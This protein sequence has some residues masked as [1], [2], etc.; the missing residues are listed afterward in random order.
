M[1]KST[2][3]FTGSM[4]AL[5][6]V[7]GIIAP[8][9]TV[10]AAGT[11]AVEVAKDAVA[12]AEKT[13]NFFDWNLA[14]GKVVALGDK[15]PQY[16]ELLARLSKIEETVKT[17]DVKA[18]LTAMD[19]LAANKDLAN[20][21]KIYAL[22]E[23]VGNGNNKLYLFNELNDWGKKAVFTPE[24]VAATDAIV[25]AQA[26]L[27]PASIAA[28]KAAVAKVTNAGSLTWLNEQVALTEKAVSLSVSEVKAVGAKKIEVKFNKAV[29]DTKAVFAVK[30]GS[31]AFNNKAVTFSADKTSAVI[32]LT[33]ALTAGDYTVSVTGLTDAAITSTVKAEDQKVAKITF[34]SDKAVLSV[35]GTTA[36]VAYKVYNQYN[37]DVT[38]SN[39]VDVTSSKGSAVAS[40]G[41]ITLSGATFSADDK[42]TLSAIHVASAT[43]QSAL[44]T[45]S[46]K[47]QVSTV[48]IK[49]LYN[50]DS[51]VPTAGQTDSTVPYFLVVEAKDQYGNDVA[52]ANVVGDVYVSVSGNAGFAVAPSFTTLDVNA[53]GTNETV[54]ALTG[55]L[56]AG[57]SV[58]TIMSKTGSIATYTVE[59]KESAKADVVTISAPELAVTGEKIEIPYSVVDQFGNALTKASEMTGV[60]MTASAGVNPTFVQD[61]VTGKAKLV[62]D[63]TGLSTKQT[64]ILTVMTPTNKVTQLTLNLL[65]KAVP[66]TISGVED[67]TKDMAEGG[68]VVLN[69][70]NVVVLDQ[71]NREITPTLGN[72]NYVYSVATSASSKVSLPSD[73]YVSTT[74]DSVTLTGADKGTSTITLS[75][76]VY[77]ENGTTP[78]AI[79]ATEVNTAGKVAYTFTSKVVEKAD[80]VSY[81]LADFGKLLNNGTNTADIKVNGVLADGSKVAVPASYFT[82]STV[83]S[84]TTIT[85]TSITSTKA[86][87]NADTTEVTT[88]IVVT[89]D[90]AN[91]PVVLV[92]NLTI[93]NVAPKAT[94]FA[95]ADATLGN[96]K[97]EDKTAGVI[98]VNATAADSQAEINAV[99]TAVVTAKDQYGNAISAGVSQVIVT[100]LPS[101]K[102]LADLVAGNTYN[103][104]VVLSNGTTMTLKVILK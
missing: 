33:S 44:V 19:D 65:D 11:T 4:A 89:V 92:K 53:D 93:T 72:T 25:K 57:K 68:S 84:N 35:A 54:L 96:A 48:A 28:A 1:K 31:I 83:A 70:E 42:V 67:F 34:V 43:F 40:N 39:S 87:P 6:T 8:A 69:D 46:N 66:T 52:A 20:Y 5:A 55:T 79:D 13:V 14:F 24:I 82:S 36:T 29:D 49:S 99:V 86:M 74:S 98:S 18:I 94:T 47:A 21:Y 56:V 73:V 80:I 104:I 63:V 60:V 38:S 61:Y 91:G 9:A 10:L 15:E 97:V 16:F 90:G 22:V 76:G 26:E 95:L 62:Y 50:V 2:K 51:K 64:V 23:K 7:A 85:G 30:K 102:T 71:Y 59:V 81:E 75:L 77:T 103:A 32:E 78:G 17:A 3:T 58:V 100:S 45:V 88:P 12:Y 27:T 37:E 41:T 101:G